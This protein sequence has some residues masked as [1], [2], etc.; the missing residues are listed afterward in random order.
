MDLTEADIHEIL[1]YL[2]SSGWDEIRLETPDL[3]LVA[4]RGG[5]PGAG[6]GIP[7]T[8]P[9]ASSTSST[10][11]SHPPQDQR[12]PAQP[13]TLP[14][15][16]AQPAA[17][18][19]MEGAPLAGTARQA[20]APS[21]GD[22][23]PSGASQAA[24]AEPPSEPVPS[25]GPADGRLPIAAPMRGVFYRAPRPGAKPFVDLG[26]RVEGDTVVGIIEVMKLMHSVVAGVSGMID[27]VCV[28]DGESVEQGQTLF[29]VRPLS[30]PKGR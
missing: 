28:A 23:A 16:G 18:A 21:A 10:P 19:P 15:A 7:E 1:K 30:G 8:A 17:P 22:A 26:S 11:P 13:A 5:A 14:V 29:W 4:R 9:P 20:G 25:T 12:A 2:D 27:E 24:R 3:K 6:A